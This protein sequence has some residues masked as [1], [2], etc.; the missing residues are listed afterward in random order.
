[1][2]ELNTV[3][4]II[5]GMTVWLTDLCKRYGMDKFFVPAVVFLFAGILTVGWDG[6]FLQTG[7][8][9]RE[10]LQK[11]FILGAMAGGFYGAGKTLF[12][13]TEKGE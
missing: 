13:S 12:K 9:W 11:G 3:S 8:G 7:F 2:E 6:L 10:S 4:F 1:M 5:I